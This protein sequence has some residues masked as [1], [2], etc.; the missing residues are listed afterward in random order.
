L[1]RRQGKYDRVAVELFHSKFRPGDQSVLFTRDELFEIASR[2]GVRIKNL[3]DFVYHY[4]KRGRFPEL[5]R[6][7]GLTSAEIVSRSSYAFTSAA[8]SIEVPENLP[9]REVALVLPARVRRFYIQAADEQGML[10]KVREAD[11]LSD[12]LG[13]KVL[14]MQNHLKTESELGQVEIDDIYVTE[15]TGRICTVEAAEP[16]EKMIRSQVRRQI[17]GAVARFGVDQQNVVAIVIRI[18]GPDKLVVLR[19]DSTLAVAEGKTYRFREA[20]ISSQ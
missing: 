11:V 5:L 7:A 10:V 20:R 18:L 9:E 17:A 2:L 4:S 12:F 15:E 19:L 6:N 1:A 3:G 16:N 8:D 13:E 14:H